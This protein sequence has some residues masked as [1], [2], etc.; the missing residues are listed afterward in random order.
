MASLYRK[1]EIY[2]M[3]IVLLLFIGLFISSVAWSQ[4]VLQIERYGKARTT[5]LFIGDPVYY[6]VKGD[7]V[8]HS[9]YIDDLLIERN[10]IALEDRYVNLGDIEAF[11][12]YQPWAKAAGI[13]LYTF[14]AAWSGFALIGTL[15]DNDPSTNYRTSD[16]VVSA[17]SVGLGFAVERLFY[18]KKIRFGERKRL[19]MLDLSFKAPE[20]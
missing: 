6:R 11:R 18:R 14:G 2:M 19:R 12:Y 10:V 1:P 20:R 16:A 15:T 17:V 3:R 13:S 5:K 4:K 9:G 7:E 8:W